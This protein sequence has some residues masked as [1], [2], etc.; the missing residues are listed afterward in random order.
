MTWAT[1]KAR[2]FQE[3]LWARGLMG[4]SEAAYLPAGLAMIADYHSGSTRSR[5]TGLHFSGGYL[6]I[7]LG[8]VVGGWIGEHYGWRRAF[9][10]LGVIG[11]VY[12][13]FAA[14]VLRESPIPPEQ[15]ANRAAIE[16]AG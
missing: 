13:L 12:A 7:V 11:I 3:L 2:S 5:A 15:K 9:I 1:G 10:V 8:G 14:A 4:V 16:R 6:G